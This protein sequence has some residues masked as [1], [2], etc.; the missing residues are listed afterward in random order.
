[1][2]EAT[3]MSFIDVHLSVEPRFNDQQPATKRVMATDFTTFIGE[4]TAFGKA[5]GIKAKKCQV[6]YKEGE[7]WVVVED[8]T[9]LEAAYA[10][11]SHSNNK[12][13][14]SIKSQKGQNR[15]GPK[16]K[17]DKIRVKF[18]P[19]RAFKNLIDSQ[20][21]SEYLGLF[22]RL[23]A[24]EAQ[25]TVSQ[26]AS[27]LEESKDS[28]QV[29]MEFVTRLMKGFTGSKGEQ[30][31]FVFRPEN[32]QSDQTPSGQETPNPPTEEEVIAIFQ[33]K[34]GEWRQWAKQKP[35]EL[36]KRIEWCS[37]YLTNYNPDG[38][39]KWMHARAVCQRKPEQTLSF[40]PG[41]TQTIELE[42][43]NDT[44]WPWANG[45]ILTLADQQPCGETIPIGDFTVNIEERVMGKE[46]TT[47]QVP[48]KMPQNFAAVNGKEYEIALSMRDC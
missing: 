30:A 12:I 19:K 29:P 39:Q 46:S 48:L 24:S 31:G 22:K 20:E 42:I 43:L 6:S 17:K 40:S 32:G 13:T 28:C 34:I 21:E 36:A 14:F 7:N 37:N 9:A 1:M 47:L 4:A 44:Y 10:S 16:A 27:A 38:S 5:N 2:V 41:A 3:R 25:I 8:E 11:A 23:I 15:R 26:S 18:I 45:S 35:E 33:T